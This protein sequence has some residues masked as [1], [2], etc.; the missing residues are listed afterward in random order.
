MSP[1]S[2][3]CLSI[4]LL[5]LDAIQRTQISERERQRERNLARSGGNTG[6]CPDSA[7]PLAN[8]NILSFSL[9]APREPMEGTGT[10]TVDAYAASTCNR[11]NQ[12]F[13]EK[14]LQRTNGD[15]KS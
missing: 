1:N 14:D 4:L 2:L 5:E 7:A 9:S 15:G 11:A 10:R 12:I 6:N 3:M 8:Q 13:P